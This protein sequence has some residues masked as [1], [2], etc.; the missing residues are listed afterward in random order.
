M[1][2]TGERK[3][4]TSQLQAGGEKQKGREGEAEA[5]EPLSQWSC[6][7]NTFPLRNLLAMPP[8]QADVLCIPM[9]VVYIKKLFAVLKQQAQMKQP[10]KKP[11]RRTQVEIYSVS[12]RRP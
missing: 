6:S 11:L 5:E 1:H 4:W 3:N 2:V 7:L 9:A 10:I 8:Y 12:D